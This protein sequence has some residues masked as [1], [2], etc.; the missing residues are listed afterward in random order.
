[1]GERAARA[2]RLS[3]LIRSERAPI[4][5]LPLAQVTTASLP[6]LQD[7]IS[8]D[9][10]NFGAGSGHRRDLVPAALAQLVST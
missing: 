10:V 2:T 6:A 1:V 3:L 5:G 7:G 8:G 4:G 9:H